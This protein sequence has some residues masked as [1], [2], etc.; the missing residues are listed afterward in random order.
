MDKL[1]ESLE[2]HKFF[3]IIFSK[4]HTLNDDFKTAYI[5]KLLAIIE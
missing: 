3:G 2:D 5:E 4:L 1:A